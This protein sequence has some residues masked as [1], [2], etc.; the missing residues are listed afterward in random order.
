MSALNDAPPVISLLGNINA[1]SQPSLAIIGARNASLNGKKFAQKLAADLGDHG[2]T[3]TSGLARG[4]DTAAHHGALQTGTIAVLAGGVDNIYPEENTDLYHKI[5]E[6]NGA[7]ISEAPLETKPI[8][9]H[10]PRRNRIVSGLSKGVIVIEATLKS[11]SLITARMAGE[12]GRDVYAMPGYPS[13]PRASGPNAL[14]RDGAILIRNAKDVIEH[15]ESFLGCALHDNH[16]NQPY[17]HLSPP[18]NPAKITDDMRTIVLENLSYHATAVDE[19]LRTCHLNNGILQIILLELE[20]AGRI[21]RLP[22]NAI[23]LI[24]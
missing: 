20:L 2:Y 14:I 10:F 23:A 19:L 24:G 18:Q 6:N 13:D 1:L 17:I 12:Q 9:H 15:Q 5:I 21:K 22:G 16:A 7:I 11:G 8:A 3:I 4:I